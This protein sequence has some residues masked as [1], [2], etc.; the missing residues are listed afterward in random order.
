MSFFIVLGFA[1]L[2]REI[3]KSP[4]GGGRGPHSSF[5]TI[6]SFIINFLSVVFLLGLKKVIKSLLE[7]EGAPLHA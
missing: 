6:L 7:G 1:T 2:S 4:G 3:A 5:L